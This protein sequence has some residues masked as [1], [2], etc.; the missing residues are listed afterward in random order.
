MSANVLY[1]RLREKGV[2]LW[3][4]AGKLRYRAPKDV[5]NPLLRA[6]MGRNK[7]ALLVLIEAESQTSLGAMPR[8]KHLPLSPA[9]TG[10]WLF[11]QLEPD[12]TLYSDGRAFLLRGDLDAERLEQA[13]L[14]VVSRHEILHTRF[15]VIDET[16]YQLVDPEH[17]P[18]LVRQDMAQAPH[19]PIEVARQIYNQLMGC[20]FDLAEGPLIRMTLACLNEQEHVLVFLVHH[21]IS[22]GLS[23]AILIDEA[24]RIYAGAADDLQPL[25]LQ[26]ADFA[27]WQRTGLES[28]RWVNELAWWKKNLNAVPELLEL[29]ADQPRP[30]AMSFQS[31][32]YRFPISAELLRRFKLA[33]R[34]EGVTPFMAG[35]AVFKALVYRYTH[36]GDL[37]V[38]TPITSR[39][40]RE[41]EGLIGCFANM[42]PLRCRVHGQMQRSDLFAAVR[43]AAVGAYAHQVVPFEKIVE[44]LSPRRDPSFPVLVQIVFTLLPAAPLSSGLADLELEPLPVHA[45]S[46]PFDLW[47]EMVDDPNDPHAIFLYNHDLFHAET[48]ARMADHFTVLLHAICV[49]EHSPVSRLPIHTEAE[50]QAQLVAWNHSTLAAPDADVDARFRA[51]AARRATATALTWNDTSISYSE[52]D[53]VVTQLA[54]QLQTM[55]AGPDSLTAIC[56]YRSPATVFAI[57][58]CLRAGTTYLPIDPALP[59]QRVSY[60]LE[61]CDVS[62]LITQRGVPVP[63]HRATTLYLDNPCVHEQISASLVPPR[64]HDENLAYVIYTSGSTGRPK[65]VQVTRANLDHM[66]LAMDRV[67]NLDQ[68]DRFLTLSTISFD[69]ATAEILVPLLAGARLVLGSREMASDGALLLEGLTRS[70][71]TAMQGTPSTWRMLMA[72]GWPDSGLKVFAGGEALPR[73]LSAQLL[74]RAESVANLY[75]PTETTVCST[76]TPL[77]PDEDRTCARDQAEPLGRPVAN[78]T[79][80]VLDAHMQPVC[81]GVSG[82]LFIGGPGLA[83]GYRGDPMRTSDRFVPN[84]FA[85]SGSRLYRSGDLTRNRSDGTLEYLGRLDDQV[86]VR[87][88]RIELGEIN[89]A[90]N[91]VDLVHEA[92]TVTREIGAGQHQL[93]AYVVPVEAGDLITELRERLRRVL[94][95][96]MVP[97]HF[98]VLDALPLTANG[99]IDRAALPGPDGDLAP[100]RAYSPPQNEDEEALTA[101]FAE[102]LH[103]ERVSATSSFFELG[104]DSLLA[105]KARTRI[106]SGFNVELPLKDLFTYSS[107]SSLARHLAGLKQGVKLPPITRVSRQHAL[108]LSFAQ[109]RMWF[110]DQLEGASSTYN[111]R[112]ALRLQGRLE[113]SS[114]IRAI[115]GLTARHENLRTLF[116]A[117]NGKPVQRILPVLELEL[118]VI[119]LSSM[120]EADRLQWAEQLTNNE[121]QRPFDLAEGPLARFTL[122]RLEDELHILLIAKHHIISDGWSLGVLISELTSQYLADACGKVLEIPL[123]SVQY[124]D[125]AAW[126]R[127]HLSGE[128][129]ERQ[130]DYWRNRLEGAPPLLELPGDRPRPA[131]ASYR[132]D[133]FHFSL[134]ASLTNRIRALAAEN[135]ATLFMVLQAAFANLL[136]R[137]S[138]QDD[139]CM[140]SPI[141]N[142]TRAEIEPLIGFFVNTLVLRTD[143][144]GDPS[145]IELLRRA[146]TTALEAFAH[147]DLPFEYL[148]E[149]LQPERS[150]GYAPL[151]QVMIILQNLDVQLQDL[152][153]LTIE[154]QPIKGVSA[155]FDLSLFIEVNGESLDCKFEYATDLFDGETV[156]RMAR[157]LVVLLG[158]I[159]D[160][161][162]TPISRLPIQSQAER[163]RQ[164]ID[165]NSSEL[166][167]PQ[168]DL[169]ARFAARARGRAHETAI[170]W[171]DRSLSYFELYES[172]TR[173]AIR[174]QEIGVGPESLVGI[175]TRRSPATVIAMLAS[176]SVGAAYVPIDPELPEQRVAY[177]MRDGDVTV[178]LTQRGISIPVPETEALFLDDLGVAAGAQSERDCLNPVAAHGQNLAYVIY[179]SG[180][181]GLPKGVGLTRANLDNLLWAMERDYGIDERDHFLA[182]ATVSF[183][184][185]GAEILLPLLVG[186]RLV[187]A[188][189]EEATDGTLLMRKLREAEITAMQGTPATWRMLLLAGWT[190]AELKAYSTGEAIPR[191]LAAELLSRTQTVFNLYGPSETTIWSSLIRLDPSVDRSNARDLSEPIGYPVANNRLYVLNENMEPQPVGVPGE[192]YIGG[193]GLARGYRRDPVRTCQRFVPDPHGPMGARLYRTG[194]LCRYRIDGCLEYL[195]RMDHQVKVRGYRIELGEIESLLDS[196]STVRQSVVVSR[197][198]MAG[199]QQLIAYVVGD[200]SVLEESDQQDAVD[201]W[202]EVWERTYSEETGLEPTFNIVGWNDSYSASAI[203]A[204]HMREWVDE[205]VVRILSG[206][207]QHIMEM[208]CGTGLLLFAIAPRVSQYHGADFSSQALQYVGRHLHRIGL[209]EDRVTLTQRGADDFSGIPERSLDMLVINS[210][211]QY[212]PSIDYLVRVIEGA[213]ASVRPGG[214]VFLGDIRS[215][216][217]L[218]A[219]HA[220]TQLAKADDGQSLENFRAQVIESLRRETELVIDPAF[221]EAISAYLP[222]ISRVEIQL[223]S[224]RYH[225]EMTRFR[226]DVKLH[227]EGE[228]SPM[229]GA[230][231]L[232]WQ[233]RQLSLPAVAELL[234]DKPSSLRLERVPNARLRREICLLEYLHA[235][236]G[237]TTTGHLR[238]LVANTP[239]HDQIE[240][241]CFYELA[242]QQGY[243]VALCFSAR[244]DAFDVCFY[245]E[246]A[247][248][249]LDRDP[250]EASDWRDYANFPLMGKLVRDL[251]PR[252]RHRLGE[253]LPE[254]MIP[255]GF[256]LLEEMPLTPNGKVDR[257]ALPSPDFLPV[258]TAYTVPRTRTESLLAEIWSEVLGRPKIGIDTNFFELGGH[259]LLA[260]QVASRVNDSFS[261][262]LTVREIFASPTIA[263]LGTV[264]DADRGAVMRPSVVPVPREPHMPLSFAQERL[265]FLDRLQGQSPTYNMPTA[266]RFRGRADVSA[267]ERAIT[268][269]IARHESLRTRFVDYEGKAWQRFHEVEDYQLGVVDYSRLNHREDALADLVAA[270]AQQNF[271]LEL[272]PLLHVGLVRLASDENVLLIN[273]HHIISDGWSLGVM[274]RELMALYGAQISAQPSGLPEP[275]IQYA[276][277]A[278]CQRSGMTGEMLERQRD[279]WLKTLDA[280]PALLSLPNDKVRPAVRTFEGRTWSFLLEADL[281][282][283]LEDLASQASVTSFM[284]LQALF[285]GYLSGLTGRDDI[286]MG[287]PVANRNRA[288]IEPLIG[289]FVNTLVLRNDLSGDPSFSSLLGHAQRCALDAFANQDIPFEQVVE[290]L[291]PERN[292]AISPIFQVMF[293]FRNAPM[294]DLTLPG[295]SI[296]TLEQESVAAKFDLTLAMAREGG[297]MRCMFEYNTALFSQERISAMAGYFK[298]L[299]L[300]VAD[301][302]HLPLARLSLLNEAERATILHKW[303]GAGDY[304]PEP[305]ANLVISRVFQDSVTRFPER[306]ALT[307]GETTLSYRELDELADKLARVLS[308]RGIGP[309]SLVGLSTE[310]CLGLGVALL[311]ILKAGAAYVPLDPSAPADRLAAI[312]QD[313]GIRL[314]VGLTGLQDHLSGLDL[315]FIGLE[316]NGS[317]T[318]PV[319]DVALVPAGPD[320][321]AYVIFTSGST[322]R[323]K[324]VLVSQANVVRLFHATHDFFRFDHS[325]VWSLFH[326]YAF[327]FSV[328]EL[329]G[330]LFYGGRCVIVPDEVR[331]SPTAFHQLLREQEVTVLN[332]TPSAFYNL[333]EENLSGEHRL[334]LR[335]VIFG[336]EAL[337]PSRLSAWFAR[338]GDHSRLVNM[339]GITETSVHVTHYQVNEDDVAA[340][341]SIIGSAM[342]DQ[343]ALILN[344]SGELVPAGVSGVLHVGGCG[345][346]RGYLNQPALTA[347]RFLPDPYAELPGGRLYNSGDLARTDSHGRI[348]YLGRVDHQVQIRGYRVELG[349]VEIAL[350]NHAEILECAVAYQSERAQ[351]IAWVRTTPDSDLAPKTGE[352]LSIIGGAQLRGLLADLAEVLPKYMQ[353]SLIVCVADFERTSGG[354]INRR[355]LPSPE[356]MSGSGEQVRPRNQ[357]EEGLTLMWAELLGLASV[358][359]HDNF[360]ESGGHSL[361]A[362]QLIHRV[363]SSFAIEVP[364]AVLFGA[365]TPAE[366]AVEIE[367]L[368]NQGNCEAAALPQIELDPVNSLKPFPLTEIQ[369][370]YWLGRDASFD[371]GGVASHAYSEVESQGLDLDRFQRAINKL[372]ARHHMLRA[373]VLETGEQRVVAVQDYPL[374]IENLR[375]LSEVD[376]QD[377]LLAIRTELSHQLLDCG[378][379]PL[380]EIRASLLSENRTRLHISYDAIIIDAW[381]SNLLSA[382]LVAFYLNPELEMAPMEIS[383]RDYVLGKQRLR[384][385]PIYTRSRDYWMAR[386]ENLAPA[387]DLPMALNPADLEKP[388]FSRHNFRLPAEQW[389]GLK[390][391]SARLGLTPSGILLACFSEILAAWSKSPRFTINLTLFNRVP[392]HAQVDQIVGDFTSLTLLEVDNRVGSDFTQ[393]ARRIQQQL[394]QDLDHRYMG[395]VEVLRE[396]MRRRGRGDAGAAMPVVFTSAL[397]LGETGSEA[398]AQALGRQVYAISQTPQVWL[399][400]QVVEDEG[401]LVLNWDVLE[402]L[403]PQGFLAEMFGEYVKLVTS[404]ADDEASWQCMA[405]L[406]LP[407][408]NLAA[409]RAANATAGPLPDGLLH[410]GFM[411]RAEENPEAIALITAHRQLSYGELYG[412]ARAIADWLIERGARPNSLVALVM[413][414]GWEQIAAV[415]GIHM[416]GAAY[417]PV[418][419]K[420]P[421]ERIEYLLEVGDVELVLTCRKPFDRFQWSEDQTLFVEESQPAHVAIGAVPHRQKPQDLAYVIFTSGSTGQPK[422]VVINHQ[423]ALNTVVDVNSS[424]TVGPEDRCFAISSMS[425]DLSVYDVFG[426]LGA[427][428]A[429]VIPSPD[430]A[431][432]PEHWAEICAKHRV[433]IWNSVPALKGM[434]A[435]FLAGHPERVWPQLR[436]VLM[437]GD[438]I[439]VTLPERLRALWPE[440]TPISMGGATE[441]A[442]WS[443][444]YPIGQVPEDWE[445]IPYG[446]PMRNQ[447]FHVYN[448]LMQPCPVWTPGHLYISGAGLALGYWKDEEKTKA[449]FF[450]HPTTGERLYRTGDLGRYLPDGNIEFLGRDDFQ[451]K[452]SGYRIEL[453]EI[454]TVLLNH[455]LINDAVVNAIGEKRGN[456]K[457]VAYLVLSD[458]TNPEISEKLR[459]D[460]AVHLPEYMVPT[461]F[462]YLDNLPLSANGK[463]NRKALPDPEHGL[464]DE[465][466]WQAPET[467]MEIRVAEICARLLDMERVGATDDFFNLG[468]DSLMAIQLITE[469]RKAFNLTVPLSALFA[470]PNVRA[471]A[472]HIAAHLLAV[473]EIEIEDDEEEWEL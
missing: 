347:Q 177:M 142:R 438:W 457:L 140:G 309:E 88:Y 104:G 169:V 70:G 274:V 223:K 403:F 301:H 305:R 360:F 30:A 53:A 292:R 18:R 392:F 105:T 22:D 302:P 15:E 43:D 101:I 456:K 333:I 227:I 283:R 209:D 129:L 58:A 324:G 93:V 145:F 146:R 71:I 73:G 351:L 57:L 148:V 413:E 339:F 158:A 387:P 311:G 191:S 328:W 436:L 116:P 87:G 254:Y 342:A 113:V 50:L 79:H 441:A 385:T 31:A 284:C 67:Y 80:Y 213:V 429:L 473:Q 184:I 303:N 408:Q 400:H 9:Q 294:G 251:T 7:E 69:I 376:A 233:Q 300:A 261:L 461:F 152:P 437:S 310:R 206:N 361:L 350:T 335:H 414:K 313:S 138:G 163:E 296:E 275:V 424:Y 452:V 25:P 144:S 391:R 128:V 282:A 95:E 349:E 434:M 298:N 338:Y 316:R 2:V 132:G 33:A 112:E 405:P 42:L 242:E 37:L 72:C 315:D 172:V 92:V 394:W 83:R 76:F 14:A 239:V 443:I 263:E 96:Y 398:A 406:L 280:A 235:P 236:V 386:I 153:G 133:K 68:E 119:D 306:G 32:R 208:G 195:G 16:P 224:G 462:V 130:L 273:M 211:A 156:A 99:K 343:R 337:E 143:L 39:Q 270:H 182:L 135:E 90:L 432:D 372:V 371:L 214:S 246:T 321:A 245:R 125:Y 190:G 260:T 334:D 38:G 442:I 358:G 425:F 379:W 449:S 415:L 367:R 29:P 115:N 354:K 199:E 325:D 188:T 431:R 346:A 382:D 85:G 198:D 352:G 241:H 111:M 147:Q 445:S 247:A 409:R 458:E 463:V 377:R 59:E 262:A 248:A 272:G 304:L 78:Y 253:N 269:V 295:L 381:S 173:L 171:R 1:D 21:I 326:S 40:S 82:E 399:D 109:Q 447:G 286:L 373:Y 185:A 174:L 250:V 393:R 61:D 320:N 48:M 192:L 336:G 210:V 231:S 94:P 468:G 103:I 89:A 221:F 168:Q 6:E 181:T 141:A 27:L 24:A 363:N 160:Q 176:L 66:L 374:R 450:N 314:V 230:E 86:K 312:R 453:G 107:V 285:S 265:W 150:L 100:G 102:V 194:D 279:F 45:T 384:E 430:A 19:E 201:E 98:V 64:L 323:P 63:E 219:F 155:M 318:G 464:E 13:L 322:G 267:L 205:S 375:D 55:G 180:S 118:A 440:V 183:D 170:A 404:L 365:P 106:C 416:A 52:L 289:F 341:T 369:Q 419:A 207:P 332:Q 20:C 77:D 3:A 249:V 84:P 435:A 380:F 54:T 162:E 28:G 12:S 448:P 36:Q 218:E 290:A 17:F 212:F 259:S 327:D 5:M 469:I 117:I 472:A 238:Q 356:A 423:A 202:S 455:P 164:L 293:D 204:A 166:A 278:V 81:M 41:L 75:G 178:M 368:R 44:M 62:I 228:G 34:A 345:L 395:G 217:H 110:L 466:A 412:R 49:A 340:S 244:P 46:V 124:A 149:K 417:L 97:A 402:E 389:T 397:A 232:D 317:Y 240:P 307:Y 120:G 114:L 187:L 11:N 35:L 357:I 4:A 422:G 47:L 426:L 252:L 123:L 444:H 167:A 353:P 370:A 411:A 319:P 428:G 268:G 355:A 154:T 136:R 410:D 10:I 127:Q 216:P 446:K 362:A 139:V 427:G 271:D 159:A 451:V 401:Q 276:D 471:L 390:R 157:H 264:V 23:I 179:T 439:P 74:E 60:M 161:A 396:I 407:E 121:V 186:A 258:T 277:F 418:Q 467:E 348:E 26:F 243:R 454:E 225:N 465:A 196:D 266:M 222:E 378:A 51:Q 131:V 197:P 291:Q 329:W 297:A 175:C 126:Q 234:A 281:L 203:P 134:G 193:A 215:L 420:W 459:A 220:T 470:S 165:W 65:G 137:Y 122:L 226:Y 288:E 91:A 299:A 421:R 308:A 364:L 151:F 229:I 433:T 8:P 359:I 383:F 200:A 56:T 366:L 331:T 237:P 255:S 388:V 189:R 330:A 344:R 287:T 108:P 256:V 257:R 460:L